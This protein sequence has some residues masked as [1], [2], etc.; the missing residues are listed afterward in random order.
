MV[1]VSEYL[2]PVVGDSANSVALV[3]ALSPEQI[4]KSRLVRKGSAVHTELLVR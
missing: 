4:T 3:L 2:P 1:E